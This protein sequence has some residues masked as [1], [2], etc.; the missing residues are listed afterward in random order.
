MS[1]VPER[2]SGLHQ[3]TRVEARATQQGIFCVPLQVSNLGRSWGNVPQNSH[4]RDRRLHVTTGGA[5][6]GRSVAGEAAPL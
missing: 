1:R 2:P 3:N 5:D 6:E 4:L